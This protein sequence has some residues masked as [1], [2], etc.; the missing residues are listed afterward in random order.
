MY[1]VSLCPFG[2]TRAVLGDRTLYSLGLAQLPDL[3]LDAL[4]SCAF[5]K[6]FH[7]TG[8]GDEELFEVLSPDERCSCTWSTVPLQQSFRLRFHNSYLGNHGGLTRSTEPSNA[9]RTR[10]AFF[11]TAVAGQQ[12]K[13]KSGYV[14][15]APY[16]KNKGACRGNNEPC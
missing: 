7:S 8:L 10:F 1:A 13:E 9:S 6:N 2:L 12:V 3:V 16:E 15:S 4:I 14:R 5:Q 11:D